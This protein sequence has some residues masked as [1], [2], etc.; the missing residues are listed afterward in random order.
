MGCFESSVQIKIKSDGE[1]GG[2]VDAEGGAAE[3][4]EAD[5]YQTRAVGCLHHFA[6][7]PAEV[8]SD[9]THVVVYA[10]QSGIE[11]DGHL[12]LSEHEA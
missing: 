4:G 6:C 10:E 3:Q 9:D 8:P 1:E 12:C 11:R 2:G 5:L 7:E